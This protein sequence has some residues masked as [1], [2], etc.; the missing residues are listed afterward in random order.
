[1]S[2]PAR[3]VQVSTIRGELQTIDGVDIHQSCF[4]YKCFDHGLN[5]GEQLTTA[6]AIDPR[7]V[8]SLLHANHCSFPGNDRTE[9]DVQGFYAAI[10]S[11]LP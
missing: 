8:L 11:R 3:R 9:D 10:R 5:L 1:V 7:G 6:V 2:D 4:A